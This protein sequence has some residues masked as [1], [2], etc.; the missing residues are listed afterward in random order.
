M[1]SRT[2]ASEPAIAST[3]PGWNDFSQGQ[4][5]RLRRRPLRPSMRGAIW[6]R[7]AAEIGHPYHPLTNCEHFTG[8]CY[9]GHQ[10]ES[11]IPQELAMPGVAV[12]ALIAVGNSSD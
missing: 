11:P 3:E 6:A 8:Y 1:N 7:A 5:A 9:K 12:S 4:E 10:G 2:T